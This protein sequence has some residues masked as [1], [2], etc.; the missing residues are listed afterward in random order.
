M[1]VLLLALNV[2][3]A[4]PGVMMALLLL[5]VL[6][7]L[8]I[9][10]LSVV[11]GLLGSVMVL[12]FMVAVASMVAVRLGTDSLVTSSPSKLFMVLPCITGLLMKG[13]EGCR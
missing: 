6:V 3:L 1:T 12:E 5:I 11:T 9:K 13:W 7:L 10:W 2:E 8:V 4:A